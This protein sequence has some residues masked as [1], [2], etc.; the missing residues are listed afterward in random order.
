MVRRDDSA[1]E[2][3]GKKAL[4][5]VFRSGEIL[6]IYGKWFDPL[7]VPPSPLLQAAFLLGGLPE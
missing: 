3:V 4:A 7:G 6:E 1:F 5:E 2:L